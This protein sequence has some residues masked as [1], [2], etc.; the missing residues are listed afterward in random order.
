[1]TK[2]LDS[3]PALRKHLLILG[4]IP[5]QNI[6]CK[7]IPIRKTLISGIFTVLIYGI[8]LSCR[9]HL[10]KATESVFSFTVCCASILT[11]INYSVLIWHKTELIHILTRF[12]K[13][14][15][16]CESVP[17]VFKYVIIIRSDFFVLLINSFQPTLIHLNGLSTRKQKSNQRN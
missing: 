14:L 5:R 9:F 15:E 17:F 16:K 10:S 4:C 2:K 12:D 7:K 1:M 8:W 11:L 6:W 13:T 3:F